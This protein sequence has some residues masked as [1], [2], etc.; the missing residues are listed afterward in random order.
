MDWTIIQT[1]GFIPMKNTSNYFQRILGNGK[2]IMGWYFED[3]KEY[4]LSIDFISDSKPDKI[5]E[6]EEMVNGELADLEE[7]EDANNPLRK[8]IEKAKHNTGIPENIFIGA[9]ELHYKPVFIVSGENFEDVY[10]KF[11]EVTKIFG[12]EI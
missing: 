5:K 10:S 6:L 8:I 11:L 1:Y 3:K 7:N 2:S 4:S 12:V 9:I